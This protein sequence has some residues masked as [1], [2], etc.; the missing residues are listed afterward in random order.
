VGGSSVLLSVLRVHCASCIKKCHVPV[1]RVE[2][3]EYAFFRQKAGG[4]KSVKHRT[5]S[6][7]GACY[8]MQVGCCRLGI[9][10]NIRGWK[11]P[12]SASERGLEP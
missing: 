9:G 3:D 8:V 2:S 5:M 7:R 10:T 4:G 1:S 12:H 6:E 11:Q